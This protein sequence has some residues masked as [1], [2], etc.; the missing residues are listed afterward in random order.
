MLK[1]VQFDVARL[2]QTKTQFKR[3][4]LSIMYA[5]LIFD[6]LSPFVSCLDSFTISLNG[7]NGRQF[8]N[9]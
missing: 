2:E 4:K 5:V 9:C 8:A 1:F 7:L 6:P 3:K